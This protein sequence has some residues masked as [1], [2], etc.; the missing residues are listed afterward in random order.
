MA[1]R[2]SEAEGACCARGS[3]R[4]NHTDRTPASPYATVEIEPHPFTRWPG[5]VERWFSALTTK[6]L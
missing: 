3:N 6:K 2:R 1:P 5:L 4:L